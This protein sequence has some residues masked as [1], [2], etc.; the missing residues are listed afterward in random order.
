MGDADNKTNKKCNSQPRTIEKIQI[1]EHAAFWLFMFLFVFDYHFLEDNWAAATWD[2]L[3]ELMTYAAIIYLN[4]LIF[5]PFLLKKKASRGLFFQ[6]G[7]HG[8][9]LY[10]HH[11][12]DGPRARF[13]PDRRLAQRI[14]NGPEH[15]PFSAHF[16]TL[17]VF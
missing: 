2:T 12:L 14:F 3:L 17:L 8:R 13:L 1:L 15:G 6:H 5:I 11:A 4:L 16:H 9:W 7:G 10:F